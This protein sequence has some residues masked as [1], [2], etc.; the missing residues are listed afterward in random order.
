MSYYPDIKSDKAN[1]SSS[2]E[3]TGGASSLG[4]KH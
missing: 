3:G 4:K 1:F 2:N